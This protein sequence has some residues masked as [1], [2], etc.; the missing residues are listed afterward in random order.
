MPVSHTHAHTRLFEG[1]SQISLQ[2]GNNIIYFRPMMIYIWIENA[3]EN[4]WRKP[5]LLLLDE[6]MDEIGGNCT[7][8]FYFYWTHTHN[9]YML[10]VSFII[11]L[12]IFHIH[13]GCC[14][15]MEFSFLHS[16]SHFIRIK[17][18]KIWKI[19]KN[20][21]THMRWTPSYM[22][23]VT[24]SLLLLLVIIVSTK[25]AQKKRRKELR[26]FRGA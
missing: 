5:L 15:V 3:S 2:R 9:Y 1:R 4:C 13:L 8:Y 11:T 18:H 17:K 12:L 10:R 26:I 22:L 7:W 24:F 21:Y 19:S 16:F 6:E 25:K 20:K 14:V 23:F